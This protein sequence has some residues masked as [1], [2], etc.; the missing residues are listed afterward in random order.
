MESISERRYELDWLRV[1][2]VLLLIPFHTAQIFTPYVYWLRNDQLHIAAHALLNFVDQFHMPLLFFVAGAATW[3][4]LGRRTGGKYLLERLKRLFVP[5][6]FGMLVFVSANHFA[7]AVHWASRYGYTFSQSFFQYYPT[8]LQEKLFPF[9]SDFGPGALWF[10]WYLFFYSL[11]LL[12]LFLF[13]RRG[14]GRGVTSWLGGFFEK[15][16]ALFLLAIPIALVLIYWPPSLLAN[17]PIFYYIIFFIYGFFL[18]SE[19]TFQRGIDKSGPIAV[20]GGV[21]TMTLYMTLIF[22]VVYR[23]DLGNSYWPMI[24]GGPG[25]W[26]YTLYCI[27]RSFNCWFWLIGLAY[28]GKNFLNFSNRFLRY[29]NEAVLPFY[30]VHQTFIV[31]IG[32]YVVQWNMDVLPKFLVIALGTFVGLVVFYDLIIKRTNVTRFLFGVSLKEKLVKEERRVS[33]PSEDG[34]AE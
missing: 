23:M 6:M 8:F 11:V 21:V 13:I 16:G 26:T 18:Y 2:V 9:Q 7:S 5:M 27:L 20:A 25:T 22:P 24:G 3:F 28:L 32:F 15:R 1:L 29:A 17:F 33:V 30:I 19:P 4:S 10:I 31:L 12:P 34:S 14:S